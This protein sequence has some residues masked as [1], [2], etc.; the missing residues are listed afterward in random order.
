M[1]KSKD[2]ITPFS[3]KINLTNHTISNP[4]SHIVRTLS[5]MKGNILMKIVILKCLWKMILLYM[6]YM[7]S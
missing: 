4:D 5:F 2:K 1:N 7:K 6:K 3:F